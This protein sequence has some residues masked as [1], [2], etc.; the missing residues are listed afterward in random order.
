V[1]RHGAGGPGVAADHWDAIF[2]IAACAALTGDE[3][4]FAATAVT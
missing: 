1:G 4:L 3:C 2:S